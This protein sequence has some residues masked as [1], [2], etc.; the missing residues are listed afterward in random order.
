MKLILAIDGLAK[1]TIYLLSSDFEGMELE[2]EPDYTTLISSCRAFNGFF[3]LTLGLPEDFGV[4]MKREGDKVTLCYPDDFNLLL[5]TYSIRKVEL[6]ARELGLC[7]KSAALN[8]LGRLDDRIP[9]GLRDEYLEW[10]RRIMEYISASKYWGLYRIVTAF[11]PS[12]GRYSQ[13]VI[14]IF[15]F[16]FFP[17]DGDRGFP[18]LVL[19]DRPVFISETPVTLDEFMS[20]LK[21]LQ[22]MDAF[23]KKLWDLK[24]RVEGEWVCLTLRS[25]REVQVTRKKTRRDNP[26]FHPEPK[27][28]SQQ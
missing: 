14:S 27:S 13:E 9:E 26:D 2:D 12:S 5:P 22:S 3:L 6:P 21:A 7:M 11:P 1:S 16:S 28:G 25:G 4:L 8:A 20:S 17:Q 15:A 18:M 24:I 19:G 23:P 10:K